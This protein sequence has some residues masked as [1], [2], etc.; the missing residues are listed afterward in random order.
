MLEL[1]DYSET[2]VRFQAMVSTPKVDNCSDM[3]S[4]AHTQPLLSSCNVGFGLPAFLLEITNRPISVR[5]Y[6]Q[7]IQSCYDIIE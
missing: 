2:D 6:H 4:S 3:P 1:M 5:V 7:R